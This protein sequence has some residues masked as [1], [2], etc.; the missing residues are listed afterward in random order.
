MPPLANRSATL[1]RD[2]PAERLDLTENAQPAL[3]AASVAILESM[4]ER[5]TADGLD[6]PQPAYAAGHSMGQYSAFVA[7]GVLSLEDGA[8]SAN[9][10]A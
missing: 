3:L 1:A 2:G 7:A 4:R 9:G 10:A 5:W 6:A 8:W